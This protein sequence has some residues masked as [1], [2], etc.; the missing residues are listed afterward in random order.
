MKQINLHEGNFF[1][2][3]LKFC[4]LEEN[5]SLNLSVISGEDG[6]RWKYK[7]QEI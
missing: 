7:T 4:M 1:L 3:G 6:Y 2:K 5:E